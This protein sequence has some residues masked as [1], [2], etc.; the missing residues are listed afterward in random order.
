M[1]VNTL[2]A[3]STLFIECCAAGIVG[4]VHTRIIR[5]TVI[6]YSETHSNAVCRSTSY[7][8][9]MRTDGGIYTRKF[10]MFSVYLQSDI[11]DCKVLELLY[12][13]II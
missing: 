4:T 10:I 1:S 6:Y 2:L 9:T 11:N 13:I 8:V 12:Y 5:I 3:V 7:I